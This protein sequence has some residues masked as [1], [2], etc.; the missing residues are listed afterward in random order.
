MTKC[1]IIEHKIYLGENIIIVVV[2]PR[3]A[4]A[5]KIG[6]PSWI[7]YNNSKTVADID[8]KFSVPYPTSI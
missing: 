3:P 4:W 7:V 6:P 8:T 5:G 1:Q 2:N